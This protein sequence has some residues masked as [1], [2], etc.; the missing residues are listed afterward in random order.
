MHT[1]PEDLTR[2]SGEHLSG[3]IC[4]DCGGNLVVALIGDA[5]LHFRCRVGHSYALLELLAAKEERLENALWAA[6]YHLEELS[7]LVNDV[8][9]RVE[10]EPSLHEA[11]LR[12]R[13]LAADLSKA[14]RHLIAAD[15]PLGRAD[16]R[17]RPEPEGAP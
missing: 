15:Q 13:D 10:H 12:R 9:P 6:V 3:L 8:L 5:H 4:P 7:A 1:L 17:T 2:N 16:P 14:V 11:F